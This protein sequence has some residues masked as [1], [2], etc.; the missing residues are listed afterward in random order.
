MLIEGM[1][2]SALLVPSVHSLGALSPAIA[3]WGCI[4]TTRS[5][6]ATMQ[7][8]IKFGVVFDIY[9]VLRKLRLVGLY[10]L[11]VS[12]SGEN[13]LLRFFVQV[14]ADDE[15]EHWRQEIMRVTR[16]TDVMEVLR[17]VD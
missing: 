16:A 4:L 12:V 5:T 15:V 2:P 7:L 17:S 10:E 6:T 1:Q 14:P 3:L 11:R 9:A 8:E 13:N